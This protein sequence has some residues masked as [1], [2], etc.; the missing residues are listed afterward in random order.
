MADEK[1]DHTV[2]T[3][4]EPKPKRTRKPRKPKRS[5]AQLHEGGDDYEVE[6]E[7][8]DAPMELGAHYVNHVDATIILKGDVSLRVMTYEEQKQFGIKDING[9][10]GKKCKKSPLVLTFKN[11]KSALAFFDMCLH[12][13]KESEEYIDTGSKVEWFSPSMMVRM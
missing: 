9:E 11:A 3:H 1:Q 7:D 10:M 13:E 4:E 2:E 6:L 12:A 5:D 8:D